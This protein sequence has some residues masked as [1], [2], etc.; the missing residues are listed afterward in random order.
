MPSNTIH[1]HNNERPSTN[2][3]YANLSN[4]N[5]FEEEHSLLN[6][7]PSADAKI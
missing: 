1:K 2:D 5:F 6:K 3:N 4:C 7:E